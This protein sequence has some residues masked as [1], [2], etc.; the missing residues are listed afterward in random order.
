VEGQGGRRF[1]VPFSA[2]FVGEVDVVGGRIAVR[3]DFELP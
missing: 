3:E 1:L 2:G